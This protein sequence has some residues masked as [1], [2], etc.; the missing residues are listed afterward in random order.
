[1]PHC[2]IFFC[3]IIYFI[4]NCGFVFINYFNFFNECKKVMGI[5]DLTDGDYCIIVYE[6]TSVRFIYV[7]L[8]NFMGKIEEAVKITKPDTT[9]TFQMWI[10]D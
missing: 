8:D 6:N 3:G 2:F 7:N 10:F 5:K 4:I 1:M 9:I